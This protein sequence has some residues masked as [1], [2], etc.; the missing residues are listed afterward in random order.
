MG[1]KLGYG[2]DR[3]CARRWFCDRQL[4]WEAGSE[5]FYEMEDVIG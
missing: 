3:R 2:I 4:G 5:V 1:E